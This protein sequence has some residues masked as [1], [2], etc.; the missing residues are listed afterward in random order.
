MHKKPLTISY[1]TNDYH[2]LLPVTNHEENKLQQTSEK[3]HRT[4]ISIDPDQPFP[5]FSIYFLYK[6]GFKSFANVLNHKH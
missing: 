2:M 5:K 1:I 6:A 4:K 3:E